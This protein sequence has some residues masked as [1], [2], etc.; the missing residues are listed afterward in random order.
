MFRLLGFSGCANNL[1]PIMR[2]IIIII[3]II[4]IIPIRSIYCLTGS[5]FIINRSNV[6]Q[7]LLSDNDW[8]DA[9]VR[10]IMNTTFYLLIRRFASR[11]RHS[12]LVWTNESIEESEGV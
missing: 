10:G 12:T 7:E 2:L 11:K 6:S 8:C 1:P 4:I 9:A 3:I 5:R